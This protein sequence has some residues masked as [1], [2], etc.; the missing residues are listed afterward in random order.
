MKKRKKEREG[1]REKEGRRDERKKTYM[2]LSIDAEFFS[3]KIQHILMKKK[4]INQSR[5]KKEVPKIE[6]HL[7]KKNPP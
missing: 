4:K 1:G 5:N 2:T 6:A 3:Y 7:Q